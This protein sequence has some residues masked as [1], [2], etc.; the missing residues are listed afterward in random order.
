MRWALIAIAL[1][2]SSCLHGAATLQQYPQLLD[3]PQ[4][5]PI[6]EGQWLGITTSEFELD[7]DLPEEQARYAAEICMREIAA[8]QAV[9]G[10]SEPPH[11]VPVRLIAMADSVAFDSKFSAR[12]LALSTWQHGQQLLL[13]SGVPERWEHRASLVEGA[14]AT[15][16]HEMAHV[17]LR[18]YFPV[19]PRW[20]AEGLAEYL[21][22]YKWS[23]DG[24]QVE[25]GVANLNA[26]AAYQHYRSV[27]LAE[28]LDWGGASVADGEA[29]EASRYGYAWA[30]VHWMIHTQPQ[31]FA[32]AMRQIANGAGAIEQFDREL[33]PRGPE[34]DGAVH[35]YMKTGDYQTIFL[36]VKTSR[37]TAQ[38]HPLTTEE[39]AQVDALIDAASQGYRRK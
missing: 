26:Y 14:P 2:F 22:S 13:L 1:L 9:M 4:T 38:V 10:N 5:P 19:Q 21:A 15:V 12:V 8:I 34:I 37:H 27:G 11:Q 20:F 31:L 23:L 16:T 30:F 35:A 7:T 33:A 39:R 6:V 24:S 17:V 25:L 36:P 29:A 3:F 32:D 28:M 18:R